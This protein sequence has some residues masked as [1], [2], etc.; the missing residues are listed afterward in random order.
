MAPACEGVFAITRTPWTT[1]LDAL[2]VRDYG[3]HNH[4]TLLDSL[5]DLLRQRRG[6][7]FEAAVERM[8]AKVAGVEGLRAIRTSACAILVD[9][10]SRLASTIITVQKNSPLYW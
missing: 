8:S 2:G 4:I 10:T 7:C 9:D 1:K 5:L 3:L 6:V